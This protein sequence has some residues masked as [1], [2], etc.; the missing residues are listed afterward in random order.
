MTCS[1]ATKVT[2]YTCRIS[3]QAMRLTAVCSDAQEPTIRTDAP[4]SRTIFTLQDERP[5]RLSDDVSRCLLG[6]EAKLTNRPY[7]ALDAISL[8]STCV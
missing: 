8:Q 2:I 6:G 4:L 3:G 1:Y 7:C 5:Q